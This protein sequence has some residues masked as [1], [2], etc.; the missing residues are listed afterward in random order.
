MIKT[1]GRYQILE[2]IGQGGMGTVYKAFDPLLERA[3]AVKV[4]ATQFEGNPHLR[5]RFFREARAAG[6][7]S[8]RDRKSVV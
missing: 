6:H 4:I 7:L 1:I 5:E 8:H 3:V 2:K